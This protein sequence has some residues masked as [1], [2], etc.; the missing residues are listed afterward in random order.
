MYT[1]FLREPNPGDTGGGLQSL[2]DGLQTPLGDITDPPQKTADEITAE[3]K[4]TEQTALKAEAFEADGT[5]LKGGYVK[6]A[7]GTLSKDPNYTPSAT[8]PIEGLDENGALLPGYKKDDTGAV[9]IDPDYKELELDDAAQATAF[10]ERVNAITGD[11]IEI[12]YPDGMDPLSPE[13]IAHYTQ[14][15]REDAAIM[16]EEHLKTKDPRAYA[17]F[18]HRAAGKPDEEFLNGNAGFVLP[19]PA[20]FNASA[21]MQA[22]VFKYSLKVQGLDDDSIDVLVKKAITDNK[23]KEKADAAYKLIDDGQKQQLLD[24]NKETEA[25]EKAADIAISGFLGKV[26]KA[27]ATDLNFI[28]SEADKPVFRKFVIDNLRYDSGTGSFSLVQKIAEDQLNVV[29]ESLFFQH[30]KGDLKAL[31]AKQAKTISAQ[32]LRLKLKDNN[33]NPGSGK[34]GLKTD[35]N[36]IPLSAMTVNNNQ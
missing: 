10:F 8:A 7:D 18:L 35:D 29:L 11:D 21:D 20:E 23:L 28:V 13:G 16:F 25:I 2:V 17:Y 31:V 24:I 5:T 15:I 12:E 6:A 33:G 32:S 14:I 36:F 22:A 1:R 27:I 19:V 3:Q 9:I 4:A 26:D 30:K 34:S